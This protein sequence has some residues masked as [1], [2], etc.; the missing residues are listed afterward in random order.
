M[1]HRH[2]IRAS[3]T[4]F[5]SACPLTL[6]G[7][8]NESAQSQAAQMPL[9]APVVSV[10]RAPEAE[11]PAPP[12]TPPKP[13]DLTAERLARVKEAV[14]HQTFNGS[15]QAAIDVSDL[16]EAGDA[17]A[18]SPKVIDCLVST[19]TDLLDENANWTDAETARV[20]YDALKRMGDKTTDSLVK[21]IRQG[22]SKR[23][24]TLFLAVKLG[25]PGSEAR[26]NR[27]LDQHG[28]VS[29]AE[30]F[31]NSGSEKL[32]DGGER[33]ANSRGYLINT[34]NGSHR[35]RWGGF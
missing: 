23:L 11:A 20:I 29:M 33:W 2:L 14:A 26:L 12:A 27:L 28:N 30:D 7:C 1:Q 6:I 32:H 19:G 35:T 5:L 13:R 15:R 34:G 21:R 16:S 25:M 17:F 9:P 3:A 31:L 10:A 22:K 24:R 8:G 18:S 4:L